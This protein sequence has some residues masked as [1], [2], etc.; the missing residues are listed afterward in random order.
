MSRIVVLLLL[1]L[2]AGCA[3]DTRIEATDRSV[4]L[5]M[6][7]ISANLTARQGTPSDPQGGHAIEFGVTG[8]SGEDTQRL[9]SSA[10]PAV[11]GGQNF[12]APIELRHEFDFRYADVAWRWRKFF[13]SGGFGIETLA[14]IGYADLDL[15]ITSATQ[16]ANEKLSS[17]GAAGGFGIVWRLRP[18][19]SLQSRIAVFGS[20]E[21]SGVSA[22]SRLEAYIVQALGRNAA[23]R[24]GYAAWS[25]ISERENASDIHVRFSGP[26]LGLDL[27]F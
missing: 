18:G 22:A 17:W 6:G 12:T 11:F 4:F 7:R 5:P 26:A 2:L 16:R 20:G 27:L 19:T 15:S 9:T 14:G 3:N 13:G 21:D 24:A 23:V 25:V 10:S 8:G 1:G